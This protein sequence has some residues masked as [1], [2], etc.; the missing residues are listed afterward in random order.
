MG[1]PSAPLW[2]LLT[3]LLLLANGAAGGA[4]GPLEVVPVADGVWAVIREFV[5][6][7][8][9]VIE[10]D[11]ELVVVDAGGSR[12]A[13]QELLRELRRISAKPVHTVV[14]TSWR[15]D[16]LLGLETLR[17]ELPAPVR[18][19][20]HV[21]AVDRLNRADRSYLAP[22]VLEVARDLELAE[23]ALAEA[24]T[25]ESEAA[26]RRFLRD[27]GD[28]LGPTR[29][30]PLPRV[31]LALDGDLTLA[32]PRG[33]IRILTLPGGASGGELVVH[34]P[35]RRVVVVGDLLTAPALRVDGY[36]DPVAWLES[37]RRLEALEW[38]TA[39]PSRGAVLHGRLLLEIQMALLETI[40]DQVTAAYERGD[41][42]Q[43]LAIDLEPATLPFQG[44]PEALAAFDQALEG[45]DLLAGQTWVVRSRDPRP[46][47][48]P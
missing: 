17:E 37:L 45:A 1:R 10:T 22:S 25:D 20:A 13:A 6:A 42:L 41:A 36:A 7:N 15:P 28:D 9:V 4:Q 29:S 16:R 38:D 24:P 12:V 47:P 44:R 21:D 43:E 35:E 14:V 18:A 26:L 5:P 33:T 23:R 40:V 30:S 46:N 39:I 8:S 31:D 19:I 27:Q 48:S 34:L 2:T 32:S 3:G 11:R